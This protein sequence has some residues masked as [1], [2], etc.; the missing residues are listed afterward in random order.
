VAVRGSLALVPR[1][2]GHNHSHKGLRGHLAMEEM[3]A[4]LSSRHP[5]RQPSGRFVAATETKPADWAAL[6]VG[7]STSAVPI[8]SFGG[9]QAFGDTPAACDTIAT[10]GGAFMAVLF[11]L[12]HIACFTQRVGRYLWYGFV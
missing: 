9:G 2:F 10:A 3:F 6:T 5:G 4:V 12:P 7:R 1:C 11:M 8:S